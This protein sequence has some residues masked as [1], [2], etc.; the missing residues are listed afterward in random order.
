M[1]LSTGCRARFRDQGSA[2]IEA[3]LLIALLAVVCLIGTGGT[4]KEAKRAYCQSAQA[5]YD[6][7]TAGTGL[8]PEDSDS[9]TYACADV[10]TTLPSSE[11]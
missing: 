1:A 3:A 8:P 7:G 10:L 9:L 4:G 6:G 11:D 2:L 5:L